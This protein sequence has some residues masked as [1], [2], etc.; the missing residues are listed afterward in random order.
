MKIE[1]KT[2]RLILRPLDISDLQT[3]CQ[4]T[5]DKENVKYMLHF[6]TYSKDDTNRFLINVTEEWKKENS[7]FYEFA[8]IYNSYH[9][10]AISLYL[11]EDKKSAEIGWVL[12]AKYHN[13]GFAT[14]CAKEIIKFA[15]TK[16]KLNSLIAH[17]D[18]R[19]FAS[20]RVMEKIGMIKIG[21]GPREGNTNAR[22]S[23]YKLDLATKDNN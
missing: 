10:G 23:I 9:I 16:L 19:N 13:Q 22:E 2:K 15:D 7:S 3:T 8:I 11:D 21:E 17:C 14:E 5:L 1:L 12:N 20:S 4:Y 6:S 18:T